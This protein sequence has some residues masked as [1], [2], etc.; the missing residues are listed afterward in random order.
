MRQ[1]FPYKLYS[2]QLYCR[3]C[4]RAV[5]HDICAMEEFSTYGGLE[6]GIPLLCVCTHCATFHV[7]FSQEFAFCRKDDVHSEYAKIYGHNRIFP[8]DWIYF[9]GAI[10]PCVVKSFFQSQDKDIVVYKRNGLTDEKYE[11][12]KIAIDHEE[13]PDGYK[14]L[15][16]QSVYTLLGDHVYHVLR[17][18][19]GIAVGVVKDETKDKLV[20]LMDDG[21]MIFISYPRYAENP[22][23]DEVTFVVRK[24]LENLSNGLSEEVTV[25][26]G[27]G[28]VYLKGFVNSLATKKAVGECVN[29]MA[30]IRGCVNM[31][32]VRKNSK[33]SDSD[34]ER[35]IWDI[36]DDAAI[37]IFKYKVKVKS[38]NAQVTFYYEDE[39]YP[40]ELRSLIEGIPGIVS[41]NL[42]GTAILKKNLGQK[43]I[44]HKIMDR[45][46]SIRFLKDLFVRVT[47]VG[48]RYLVEG[49]VKNIAQREFALL[50][51]AGLTKSV[52]VGNRLR[53]FK[54]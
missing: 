9:D 54:P 50:V 30:G 12:P 15:P 36:L 31:V 45:L 43:E 22:P 25:E 41:L 3:Q 34:L 28:I 11:G 48:N 18:Q 27:Q 13:S 39:V 6:K 42:S 40:T 7:A 20:A 49:R 38:G 23:N 10:R 4:R 32:R 44:C 53:I 52:S 33:M 51:V 8:G 37:P 1:F 24:R 47:Y 17:K 35:C 14:L 2:L 29:D 5:I 19:F 46:A 16:V 21:M 26:A